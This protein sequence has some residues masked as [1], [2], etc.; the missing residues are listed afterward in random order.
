MSSRE[1]LFRLEDILEAL[2]RIQRYSVGLDLQQFATDQRTFDA[3]IRNL[4]IIGEAARHIPN[5][6]LQQY[7]DVPWRHMQDMRNILIHEYFGIDVG[8]IWQT[9]V[10]DLPTLRSQL[11]NI[12]S[13]TLEDPQ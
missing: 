13:L 2:E 4:Q 12:R 9:I 7:P 11:E 3:V 5:S 10:H 1:W 8:I 6:I